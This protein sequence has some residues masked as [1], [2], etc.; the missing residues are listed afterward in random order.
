MSYK[1]E[2]VY[3]IPTSGLYGIN[4]ATLY[5]ELKWYKGLSLIDTI[6][7]IIPPIR[8]Y[9]RPVRITLD[10]IFVSTVAG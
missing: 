5:T 2:D 1:E 6:D 10:D 9:K 7:S 8:E 3:F 4:L